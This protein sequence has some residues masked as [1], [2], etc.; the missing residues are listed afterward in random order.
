MTA[1][2]PA[3]VALA[4]RYV[5][6]EPLRLD[7]VPDLYMAQRGLETDWGWLPVLAPRSEAEMRLIVEQR[8][9]QQA[10]GGAFLFT[11]LQAGTRRP[12][13][14]IAYLDICVLDQRLDIGWYWLGAS[15]SGTFAAVEI[16]LLLMQ[17]AFHLGFTRVQWQFDD[18]DRTSHSTMAQINAV[19]EGL[20]RRH[21]RRPDGSWRDTVVYSVLAPKRSLP[22]G[23]FAPPALPAPPPPRQV[24]A[25]APAPV[26][27]PAA[28]AT[29]MGRPRAGLGPAGVRRPQ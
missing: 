18:L 7:H 10:A 26:R 2:S 3:P 24:Q 17:H 9:A 25:A 16:H 27:W 5:V 28:G 14:W 15:L 13:G 19:R 11:V 6:L 12:V 21:V 20:L 22:P 8:L 23:A 1:R 4:G 29:G